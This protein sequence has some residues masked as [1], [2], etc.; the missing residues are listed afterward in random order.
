VPAT[1]PLPPAM[2]ANHKE[3]DGCRPTNIWRRPN[4]GWVRHLCDSGSVFR[5]FHIF[6]CIGA[7]FSLQI[8][9]EFR[10]G[11][12]G[13]GEQLAGALDARKLIYRHII[14]CANIII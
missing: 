6:L 1:P 7:I 14:H 9:D 4:W 12:M 8:G 3:K 10:P 13:G 11:G 5:V 2:L